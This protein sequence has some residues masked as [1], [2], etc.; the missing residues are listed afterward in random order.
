L[1][2][3]PDRAGTGRWFID[4]LPSNSLTAVYVIAADCAERQ[5]LGPDVAIDL[6]AID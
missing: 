1:N 5:V 3:K 4:Q 2:H 6:E